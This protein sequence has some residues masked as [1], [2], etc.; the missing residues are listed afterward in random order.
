MISLL[1]HF[2]KN[3]YIYIG[4]AF[5]FLYLSP[6]LILGDDAH[7]RVHDNL[8]S[9]VAWYKVLADSGKLFGGLHNQVP[10]IMNGIPR[11]SLEPDLN[12]M[13]LL[14]FFF[15]P[16]TAYT[17]NAIM[18][19]FLAFFGMILLLK[20]HFIK[21]KK[22]M[23]IVVGTAVA[24]AIIPF[25]PSGGGTIAGLPM[26]LYAFLNLRNRQ[27]SKF[28]WLIIVFL[29]FYSSFVLSFVFFLAC[30]G[31][32]WLTD[33]IRTKK[34]NV[35]FL[36]GLIIMTTVFLFV[37]YRIIYEMFFSDDFVSHREAF[38][39]GN[40]DALTSLAISFSN[41]IFGQTH[42]M[43]MTEYIVL[44]IILI[45]LLIALVRKVNLWMLRKL[46]LLNLLFSFIYGIYEW[47]G[48]KGIKE[49][50][51]IFEAFNWGRFHFLEPPV[52]Y[53]CFALSLVTIWKCFK[54]FGKPLALILLSS[55]IALLFL[56]NDEIKYR[57]YHYLTYAEF[58]SVNLFQDIKAYIGKDPADYR[59]VSLGIHPSIAQYNGFYTLDGYV[60]SYPL[61]YKR[62]F[63]EIIAPELDKD[64]KI[65]KYFD[66]WGSRAYIFTDELGKHYMYDSGQKKVHHLDLNTEILKEMG[67]EYILSAVQIMNAEK[68]HLHLLKS[69][70]NKTSPWK[71]YLYRVE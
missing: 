52:W 60:V 39:R 35:V 1:N 58:Y 11:N 19:R 62:E 28:D 15:K 34:V 68:E 17:I 32:L 61:S 57:Y 54:R 22:F 63:R 18:M 38:N 12:I 64:N 42:V 5:L 48:T 53:I 59:V 45:T 67:G 29:P 8:D 3:N 55:Q 7:V 47:E 44:P 14:Y 41:F 20:S 56:F 31:F 33:W 25:W 4:I 16:F 36:A 23:A 30:M 10:N 6:Y 49:K 24:F 40:W 70:V 50:W 37:N 51:G 46:F 43:R 26:A 65:R 21:E 66:N 13:I 71:I 2:K 9:N 27:E 69:F